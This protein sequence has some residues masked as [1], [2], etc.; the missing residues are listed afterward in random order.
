MF[1]YDALEDSDL[2][3]IAATLYALFWSYDR[4]QR[5]IKIYNDTLARYCRVQ[6]RCIQAKIEE[7]EEKGYIKRHFVKKGNKTVR[8]IEVLHKRKANIIMDDVSQSIEDVSPCTHGCFQEHPPH[9]SRNTHIRSTYKIKDNT[10]KDLVQP[11]GRTLDIDNQLENDFDEKVWLATLRREQRKAALKAYK[12]EGK[13]YLKAN[14]DKTPADFADMIVADLANR[15]ANNW[16]GRPKN[17]IPLLSTYLNGQ[18]W[19]DEIIAP[20]RS[21]K[22]AQQINLNDTSW[23]KRNQGNDFLGLENQCQGMTYEPND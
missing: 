2:D 21:S 4:A 5:E 7:L 17:M 16:R 3:L 13:A 22:Q 15:A 8:R 6:V 23:D 10:N 19:T 11:V 14:P 18:Q 12:K 9:V 1:P 20:D